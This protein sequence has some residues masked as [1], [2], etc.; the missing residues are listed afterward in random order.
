MARLYS[1]TY[2]SL[3]GVMS[4]PERWTSP[5]FSDEMAQDLAERL[6]SAAGMVLGRDTYTE[7]ADFWPRQGRDVPFAE[8]NNRIRKYVVSGSLAR[9]DWQ[10]SVLVKDLDGLAALRAHGDLHIT[11]SGRLIRSLLERRLLDEV[12]IMMCPVALGHGT[13]LF[14]G[15][16]ARGLDLVDVVQF[17][18]GVLSLTFQP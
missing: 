7:F 9:A 5:Y 17:P 14:E 1:Y 4:S 6:E 12:V 16:A 18:R 3:D 10:N 2:M 13:H 8:I 15:L 11:G